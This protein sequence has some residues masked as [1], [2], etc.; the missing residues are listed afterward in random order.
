L[1]KNGKEAI[2][3][4]EENTVDFIISDWNMPNVSGIELLKFVRKNEA[5]AH[6]PFMLVTAEVQRESVSSAIAEGVNEFLVKPFTPASFSNKVKSLLTKK[7]KPP[8]INVELDAPEIEQQTPIKLKQ[9]TTQSSILVVDDTPTNIDVITGIL[10]EDYRILA[11]TSG[12]KALKIVTNENQRPD[13]IL[14]DIM[15]PEMDGLEVCRQLKNNP[16]TE[17]IPVIFLTAKAEVDDITTGL[18]LGAVDYITKP[19]NPAILIARVNTQ[20]KLKSARDDLA[21]QLDTMIENA[22]L[23]EDVERMTKH[24][25]K[26]PLA[27]VINTAD[28]LLNHK[29]LAVEQKNEIEH[30]RSNSYTILGMI[31]RSLDL[32]KMEIGTY[33]FKAE[34]LNI[35]EIAFKVVEDARINAHEL[36]VAVLFNAVEDCYVQGEDLLCFSMLSNL[37]R[38]A[39]E[40]SKENGKVNI[41]IVRDDKLIITIH[42]EQAIPES[43]RENFFD[44]YTTQG[45]EGGTGL[46][47]YSAKLMADVQ[48]AEISFETSDQEGTTVSIFFNAEEPPID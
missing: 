20:L 10:K 48:D 31:N 36:G 23:R 2:K 17:M 44:K 47:T 30:I 11:A 38:N 16:E 42:N 25:L 33:Q 19:V 28:S 18:E 15:M 8:Q 32:Y 3:Y 34:I 22:K 12:E 21:G 6:I 24:D 43:I 41:N 14:L 26:N 7:G 4:L 1:A 37:I 29:F 39:I 45:K 9:A 13:L 35:A 5:M 40:A 46:G 27:A